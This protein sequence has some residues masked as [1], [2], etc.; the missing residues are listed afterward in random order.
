LKPQVVPQDTGS[1]QQDI[2]GLI[3]FLRQ[4]VMDGP[5]KALSLLVVKMM[6]V[7][8]FHQLIRQGDLDTVNMPRQKTKLL[9]NPSLRKGVEAQMTQMKAEE[10]K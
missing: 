8:T 3:S 4:V 2:K 6:T 5:M 9:L 10:G 1:H 7:V